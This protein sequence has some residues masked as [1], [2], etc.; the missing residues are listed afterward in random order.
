MRGTLATGLIAAAMA[1]AP[2]TARACVIAIDETVLGDPDEP[3]IGAAERYRREAAARAERDGADREEMRRLRSEARQGLANEPD[4]HA[5]SLVE[6]FVPAPVHISL[7]LCAEG[8]TVYSAHF[9]AA[10][11]R[12]I[13]AAGEHA[14]IAVQIFEDKYADRVSGCDEEMRGR[15]TDY[16]VAQ[17]ASEKLARVW[18]ELHRLG[19]DRAGTGKADRL[20]YLAAGSPTDLVLRQDGQ[21]N[22]NPSWSSRLANEVGAALGKKNWARLRRFLAEDPDAQDLVA[23]LDRG[24]IELGDDTLP[25]RGLCPQTARAL[26][27]FVA[28]AIEDAKPLKPTVQIVSD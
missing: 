3:G 7:G 21:M 16:I 4:A 20:Y 24:L 9:D 25:Y 10:K 22:R 11:A 23:A 14:P 6:S 27:I 5:R 18:F 12:F 2:S 1:L 8:Y 15:L 26:E 28:Q 13:T 17:V 19:F